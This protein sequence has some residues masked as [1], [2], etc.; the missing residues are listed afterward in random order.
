MTRCKNS[1]HV[2]NPFMITV[3][4]IVCNED[5]FVK[6]A[7]T[8]VL[9]RREVSRVLVWDAGSRDKT[10]ERILSIKDPRIEFRELGRVDRK[11]MVQYRNEQIQ[12]TKTPWFML[13]DGDEIWPRKNL[14]LLISAIQ[15]ASLS[16]VAFVCRTRN[17]VGDLYHYLS[18]SKGR[19]QIGP[20]TGH[21]NIR[22][23]RNIRGL[24]VN[25]EYPNEWYELEGKKIQDF[26]ECAKDGPLRTR[27]TVLKRCLQFVDTWY[28]HMTHLRRSSSLMAELAT[29]DRLKKRKW[30]SIQRS[31][32][33][34]M[35]PEELP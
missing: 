35:K 33:L 30:L 11:K 13:V 23:I 19:Y 4:T 27:R 26:S 34:V 6:A 18:D 12:K 2:Q 16:T 22:A 31:G 10:V 3:H 21:L 32:A 14:E 9:V 24:T 17:V 28:L 15:P 25:G 20:W 8:S 7:L 1:E 5:R 29:I